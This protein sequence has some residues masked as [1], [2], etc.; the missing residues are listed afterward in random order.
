MNKLWKCCL[1]LLA[2]SCLS[3]QTI[4][5]Y[6]YD[7]AG[8]LIAA[9][10][11]GGNAI[12]YTYDPAGNLLR[13][14]VTSTAAFASVSS[15]SFAPGQALAAEV[16]AAGF[17]PGLAS[18]VAVATETPLPTELL[19]TRVEVTDSQGTARLAQLFFVSAGQI[20]YLIPP[21]TALGLVT[22]RVIS[23]AG[24]EIQGTIQIDQVAPSVYAANS[25]GNGVAAA[26]FL[27]VNPDDSR[28]QDLLFDPRTGAAVPLDVSSESGQVFLLLFGTGFRGFQGE[29]TAT[30]GGE[31]VRVLG[32][33]PQGEFVGLDQIN[34]GPLPASLTGSGEVDIVLTADGKTANVVTVNI[35]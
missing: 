9:D 15:A 3:A 10:Y 13:R 18:G 21:G 17:G 31:N 28:T 19:G 29:V 35:Q 1:F 30:V 26:F 23:G 12:N 7:E 27:R 33:V 25:Q 32:A 8:R 5:Q 20:N 11:G 14:E 24:G 2:A 22:V 6:R 4:I 16:I 34:I